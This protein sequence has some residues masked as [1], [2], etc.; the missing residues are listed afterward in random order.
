MLVFAVHMPGYA[1]IC[2]RYVSDRYL[3]YYLIIKRRVEYQTKPFL[4]GEG[5][6]EIMKRK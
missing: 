4:R 2:V 1:V 5:P 3:K 6:M